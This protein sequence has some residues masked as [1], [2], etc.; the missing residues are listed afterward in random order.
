MPFTSARRRLV[1]DLGLALPFVDQAGLGTIE[2]EA[3]V[4]GRGLAGTR[5]HV[6]EDLAP[7]GAT[8]GLGLAAGPRSLHEHRSGTR[9]CS[10][11]FGVDDARSVGH[12]Q[13]VR[14]LMRPVNPEGDVCAGVQGVVCTGFEGDVCD[15][16]GPMARVRQ[17][18]ES[19]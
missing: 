18:T 14:P 10:A 9:E 16:D 19:R 1:P 5:V 17:M 15:R 11:K 13:I 4:D 3:R 2:D 8:G 12:A 6:K 7:G